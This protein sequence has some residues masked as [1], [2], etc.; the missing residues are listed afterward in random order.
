MTVKIAIDLSVIARN[1]DFLNPV[2]LGNSG[3]L[4]DSRVMEI[5]V[6][7]YR[8]GDGSHGVHRQ[9]FET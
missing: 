5:S 3:L 6:M 9:P 8:G 1:D 7:G 4:I 2:I